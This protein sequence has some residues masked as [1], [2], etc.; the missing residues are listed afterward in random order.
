MNEEKNSRILS[1]G[2]GEEEEEQRSKRRREVWL[3]IWAALLA[4]QIHPR[5]ILRF[6]LILH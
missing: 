5:V 6:C 2:V 3:A 4:L 1:G